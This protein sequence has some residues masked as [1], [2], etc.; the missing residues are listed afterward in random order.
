MMA[1]ADRARE[2]FRM[3]VRRG[4]LGWGVL[5]I[6]LG[7]VPLA[8]QRGLLD[9]DAVRGAWQLWPLILIGAG[10]GLVLGQTRFA[11]VGTLVVAVTVGV[12]GGA[13]LAG[14][15]SF[16]TGFTGAAGCGAGV[17][18]GTGPS[19]PVQSGTLADPAVVRLDLNCGE[20]AAGS[21]PG[22]GWSVAGSSH[23]GQPP[24]ITRTDRRLEVRSPDTAG[25]TFGSQGSAWQ[26]TLPQAP[27]LD[28]ALAVNAGSARVSGAGLRLDQVD[29]SVNAGDAHLDLAA[30]GG[31]TALTGSVNAG[32][33]SV[34]LPAA[35][36]TGDLSANLGSIEICVPRDV[37]LRITTGEDPM[38]AYDL[39]G[40][41]LVH[42]GNTW[43]SPGYASAQVR[44]GLDLEANLGSISLNP[45]GG[46][47]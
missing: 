5:F 45:E 35:S 43:T 10:L 1:N 16:T 40:N 33:M 17:G 37:A 11:V 2:E 22:D 4:L 46:C 14:G 39:E 29:A 27:V 15:M 30:A 8:V 7:A 32:S 24:Q 25:V 19:F 6:V 36:L 47:D 12:M 3:R 44:I 38:A 41:G 42:A 31:L 18:T 13:V 26:V 20:L 21:A 9:A 23:D 28:L 34:S